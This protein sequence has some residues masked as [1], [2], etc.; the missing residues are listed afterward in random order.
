LCCFADPAEHAA[1]LAIGRPF[2]AC[3]GGVELIEVLLDGDADWEEIRELITDSDCFLA[4]K[5]LNA[6][7]D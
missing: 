3:K 4:P 5:K 7:L 2:L 1:P 6:L